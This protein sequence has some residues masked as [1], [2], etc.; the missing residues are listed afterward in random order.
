MLNIIL[1]SVLYGI[2]SSIVSIFFTEKIIRTIFNKK[3]QS[4]NYIMFLK[5][6]YILVFMIL[7]IFSLF[8]LESYILCI[9]KKV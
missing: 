8:L 9:L 1:L 6:F 4:K 5:L 3:N 2:S 7:S